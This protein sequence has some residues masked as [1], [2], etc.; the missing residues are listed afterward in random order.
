MGANLISD[1]LG[2]QQHLEKF[3]DKIPECVYQ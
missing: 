2:N 1:K 3:T